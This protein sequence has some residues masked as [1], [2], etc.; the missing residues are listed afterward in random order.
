L[1]EH[2]LAAKWGDDVLALYDT[3]YHAYSALPVLQKTVD[4]HQRILCTPTAPNAETPYHSL[5]PLNTPKNLSLEDGA[6]I[7]HDS[8]VTINYSSMVVDDFPLA[9]DDSTLTV[10]S[11]M[12]VGDSPMTI[13]DPLPFTPDSKRQ[14]KLLL[15]RINE[16]RRRQDAM[17]EER[18]TEP[19]G[20]FKF[21]CPLCPEVC[22]FGRS[23]LL[24]HL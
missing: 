9:V 5:D 12:N 7:I 8:A 24:G 21:L 4:L 6:M 17:Q 19:D 11:A 1:R 3:L 2:R 15:R 16:K 22:Y 10:N 23:G 20:D 13:E 14:R 18:R